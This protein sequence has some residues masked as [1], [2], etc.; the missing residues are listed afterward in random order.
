MAT[1]LT[2][3]KKDEIFKEFAGDAGNTGS[4]E[5]QVALMTFR[6]KHLSDH[7]KLNKKDHSTRRSLLKLVGKRKSL[8]TYLAARDI[9]KYRALI[10]KL[11]LRDTLKQG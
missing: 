8:L 4:T 9:M 1:Y 6:I 7:L 3:E 11:G 2:K 10:A 5:G